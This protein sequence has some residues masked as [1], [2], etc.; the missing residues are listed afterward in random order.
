ML[1]T[2]SV[3]EALRVA[4][5]TGLSPT[6]QERLAA[7]TTAIQELH[8]DDPPAA[9]TPVP[10]DDHCEVVDFT[11]SNKVVYVGTL[12][13]CNEYAKAIAETGDTPP[14]FGVRPQQPVP[15]DQK[16]EVLDFKVGGTGIAYN[17]TEEH[18]RIYIEH[19]QE[20]LNEGADKGKE[21]F[22]MQEQQP[23]QG[24][25]DKFVPAPV[26]IEPSDAIEAVFISTCLNLLDKEDVWGD[27]FADA[28]AVRTS[29][30][31]MIVTTGTDKFVV[32]AVPY[33]DED[34]S[35]GGK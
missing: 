19:H 33:K 20:I 2:K 30:T 12:R 8:E 11:K 28:Q 15:P 14:H 29:A 17:G 25:D 9:N 13:E 35:T 5:L 21:R 10:P 22:A 24:A 1:V 7:Y 6:Q 34:A 31:S 27:M 26:A 23:V 4:A 3:I 32:S 18:C 16:W